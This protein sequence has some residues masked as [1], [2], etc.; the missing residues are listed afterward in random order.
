MVTKAC[1]IDGITPEAVRHAG[2]S[3]INVLTDLYNKCLQ[4]GYVPDSF[5]AGLIC[6]VP[7]KPGSCTK[8][9][10]YRPNTL[11]STFSKILEACLKK[12]I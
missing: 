2:D 11:I 6:P 4:H 8:F 3:P 9:E 5:S 1:S 7:K 10:H 12:H